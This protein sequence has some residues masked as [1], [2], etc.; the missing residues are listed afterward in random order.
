MKIRI[1]ITVTGKVQGVS[2]RKQ[3]AKTAEDLGVSGWVM[4]LSDGSVQGCFDGD[5]TAVEALFAWCSIGPERASVN[6]LTCDIL[7]YTGEF[8]DFRILQEEEKAA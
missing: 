7:P 3:A 1:V 6:F 2:F 5:S 4:N 8:R